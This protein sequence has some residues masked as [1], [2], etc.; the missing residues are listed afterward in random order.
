M[1]AGVR[2]AVNN[3]AWRNEALIEGAM[4]AA[5]KLFVDALR[6]GQTAA[7]DLVWYVPPGNVNTR[8]IAYAQDAER[9]A[10]TSSHRQ[11]VDAL[12]VFGRDPCPKCG[13]RGELGC[14]HRGRV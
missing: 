5:N 9:A 8:G 10:I 14:K 2:A 12:R 11:R 1:V 13:G 6:T 3:G 4:E 7:R